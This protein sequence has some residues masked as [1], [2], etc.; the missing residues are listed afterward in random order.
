MEDPARSRAGQR[1]GHPVCRGRRAP[2]RPWKAITYEGE[3]ERV[4]E[5]ML[6][7]Y[8]GYG[9]HVGLDPGERAD[10]ARIEELTSAL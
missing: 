4:L 2:L 9:K 1:A 6:D 8:P 7:E 5:K 10:R 3:G